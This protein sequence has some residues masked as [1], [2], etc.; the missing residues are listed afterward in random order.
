MDP[1]KDF[2]YDKVDFSCYRN[3]MAAR[4]TKRPRGRPKLPRGRD[5]GVVLTI[6]LQKAERAALEKAA[7]VADQPISAW[8][9]SVL[10]R[11]ASLG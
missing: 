11:E 2:S 7:R 10:L 5:R 9:R 6:R 3:L 4:K 1:V 8:A